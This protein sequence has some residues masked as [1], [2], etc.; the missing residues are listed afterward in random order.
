MDLA[1]A[2]R[3]NSVTIEIEAAGE[4]IAQGWFNWLGLQ[5]SAR[6]SR[7][8]KPQ[9]AWDERWEKHLKDESYEPQFTPSYGLVLNADELKTMRERHAALTADGSPSPFVAAAEAAS[10]R[11]PETI[12]HDFVNFWSETRYNRYEPRRS[13]TN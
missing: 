8:L 1:G 5:H 13:V 9:S 7:M 6:L 11:D 3:L 12:I 4:G 10:A 2:T